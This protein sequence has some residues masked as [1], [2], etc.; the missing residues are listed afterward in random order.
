M[1]LMFFYA[2]LMVES[3]TEFYIYNVDRLLGAV[4]GSLGLTLGLSALTVVT[5]LVEAAGR[6]LKGLAK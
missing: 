1:E 6:R 3:S 4:G 5:S 2:N